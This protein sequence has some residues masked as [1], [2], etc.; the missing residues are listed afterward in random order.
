LSEIYSEEKF[1]MIPENVKKRMQ[2]GVINKQG[3]KAVERKLRHQKKECASN[4]RKKRVETRQDK[5][6]EAFQE[7][8]AEQTTEHAKLWP[9]KAA[10][11][12]NEI[13]HEM[14][15]KTW[16]S[17]VPARSVSDEIMRV[18]PSMER[19][20]TDI[21]NK[22][23]KHIMAANHPFGEHLK[24]VKA[25]AKAAAKKLDDQ[26][27]TIEVDGEDLAGLTE[28]EILKKYVNSELSQHHSTSE[29]AK[30]EEQNK[31]DALFKLFT[32]V[33]LA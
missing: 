27:K 9:M 33:E 11:E 15:T 19:H 29:S 17:K 25:A 7:L 16:W 26:E 5:D 21:V 6:L 32:R 30:K 14:L 8:A 12:Q 1:S 3:S 22:S 4:L 23:K 10:R 2:I 31:L 13:M 18:I 28:N 20:R 24:A